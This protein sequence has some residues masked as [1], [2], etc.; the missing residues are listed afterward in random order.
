MVRAAGEF[1]QAVNKKLHV[2]RTSVLWVMKRRRS[3]GQLYTCDSHMQHDNPHSSPC[4]A[5]TSRPRRRRMEPSALCYVAS[6]GEVVGHLTMPLRC[7]KSCF[8][9]FSQCHHLPE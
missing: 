6:A 7:T 5:Q 8:D 1:V 2:G 9:C 3:T 4:K